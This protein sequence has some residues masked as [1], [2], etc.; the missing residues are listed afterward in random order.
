MASD[1]NQKQNPAQPVSQPSAEAANA[2]ATAAVS[3][4]VPAAA[5]PSDAT[6]AYDSRAQIIFILPLSPTLA[7]LSANL[8]TDSAINVIEATNAQ[9]AAQVA[10]M[11]KPCVVLGAIQQ[12]SDIAKLLTMAV[13]LKADL[14][15]GRIKTVL[16]SAIRQA[17]VMKKFEE[18]GC[19]EFMLEPINDKQMQFKMSQ[20]VKVNKAAR[21][22]QKDVEMKQ[23]AGKKD[24]KSADDLKL[25]TNAQGADAKGAAGKKG[26][27]V[28]EL[29]ANEVAEDCWVFK[30]KPG[31]KGSRWGF[32]AEGPDPSEGKWEQL[33]EKT[34]EGE[35]QWRYMP[36]GEDKKKAGWTHTGDEPTFDGENWN[37]E[38]K[39]P[40]LS[41]IDEEGKKKATKFAID[42]EGNALAAADSKVAL[43]QALK[44]E[45]ARKKAIEEKKNSLF[46]KNKTTGDDDKVD[47]N[48]K[49]ES[50]AEEESSFENKLKKTDSENQ[51]KKK[52]ANLEDLAMA[53][54][55][56]IE[57]TS[58]D[59]DSEKK[60]NKK[61]TIDDEDEEADEES[62]EGLNMAGLEEGPVEVNDKRQGDEDD[63]KGDFKNKSK[64]DKE[65]GTSFSDDDLA[66]GLDE[67]T[68][69]D[70]EDDADRLSDK[71]FLKK[72]KVAA[73]DGDTE[74]DSDD[75]GSDS[76]SNEEESQSGKKKGKKGG[77]GDDDD[78]GGDEDG[79]ADDAETDEKKKSSKKGSGKKKKDGR[80]EFDDDSLSEGFEDEKDKAPDKDAKEDKKKK[81][82]DALNMAGLEDEEA[83]WNDDSQQSDE[84]EAT[85]EDSKE[86]S[87]RD[88]DEDDPDDFT[89]SEELTGSSN[90]T[91]Q[92]RSSRKGLDINAR[93]SQWDEEDAESGPNMGGGDLGPDARDKKGSDDI[94]HEFPL[95]HFGD[96]D[97]AWEIA[98]NEDFDR[99]KP[100]LYVFVTPLLKMRR[101]GDV[102]KLSPFWI[103]KNE[104]PLY[105][106]KKEVWIF[107]NAPPTSVATF[108]DLPVVVQKFLLTLSPETPKPIRDEV[109]KAAEEIQAQNEA[110]S[111]SEGEKK[112][113][114][115]DE[116]SDLSDEAKDDLDSEEGSKNTSEEKKKKRTDGYSAD[117][118]DASEF[119]SDSEEQSASGE[120]SADAEKKSKRHSESGDD[121]AE[122]EGGSSA[123][124]GD[125]DNGSSNE[126]DLDTDEGQSGSDSSS[127]G[128]SSID[129]KQ[130]KKSRDVDFNSDSD[131]A[132]KKKGKEKRHVEDAEESEDNDSST[133]HKD[134]ESTRKN[135]EASGQEGDGASRPDGDSE[136]LQE[137]EKSNNGQADLSDD[138]D[139]AFVAERWD[140]VRTHPLALVLKLSD[141]T[142]SPQLPLEKAME[143]A[144]QAVSNSFYG[145]EIQV[146]IY[147]ELGEMKTIGGKALPMPAVTESME[148]GLVRCEKQK[149]R[150]TSVTQFICPLFEGKVCVG[151]V[152]LT[153]HLATDESQK[154]DISFIKQV[155]PS[156]TG[157]AL[158]LRRKKDVT[159]DAA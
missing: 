104:R 3:P 13:S 37:F 54:E 28:K 10:M 86:E 96:K 93:D 124:N 71:N 114:R 139:E 78:G 145:A 76:D 127:D 112:R 52:G 158:G 113:R 91:D 72:K 108:F 45:E 148:F 153:T 111:A 155:C 70:K 84:E 9:E 18:L 125:R 123:K 31:K 116:D 64:K 147:D 94:Y 110:A 49:T 118:D 23:L 121:V 143:L 149:R 1:D 51:E 42:E 47:L 129:L 69:S 128:D 115:E 83:A 134:S 157:I 159:S 34:P 144:V 120:A 150:S 82:E 19:H 36:K 61:R 133:G 122:D 48:D 132:F 63:A 154:A 88:L 44:R 50:E 43:D 17:Q 15:G 126:S 8:K 79:T 100:R 137:S 39:K 55:D 142:Q 22:K 81:R 59:K 60:K 89:S 107:R 66:V 21:K 41:Y 16:T 102:T 33:P 24:E 53:F 138:D 135:G 68:D 103:C 156:F 5:A 119:Q 6:E 117:N 29:P 14:R 146:G 25:S 12:N 38:G 141:W 32:K 56:E 97:G 26:G 95:D 30:S 130:K 35:T 67:E 136:S 2:T 40:E 75:D 106:K 65:S 140:G 109:D 73:K 92:S 87:T 46:G 80:S 98:G 58:S 74:D 4:P 62:A 11:T 131:S 77:V 151:I 152:T 7:K 27:G 101:A 20:Q 57:K 105:S 90:T 85:S 99:D